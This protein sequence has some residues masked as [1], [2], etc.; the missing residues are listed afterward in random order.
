[1]YPIH[2][3]ANVHLRVLVLVFTDRSQY[4]EGGRALTAA[5][6][7]EL[8]HN[9]IFSRS[10]LLKMQAKRGTTLI[11][12]EFL[13]VSAIDI[14]LHD[15]VGKKFNVPVYQLLGGTTNDGFYTKNDVCVVLKIDAFCTKHRV[16]RCVCSVS[17]EF[18]ALSKFKWWIVRRPQAPRAID[19]HGIAN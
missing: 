5:I 11:N 17:N 9:A 2:T 19:V 15:I 6:A 18:R 12:D 16:F 13:S 7:G 1:M 4:F 14:A 10:F 8:Q 3:H